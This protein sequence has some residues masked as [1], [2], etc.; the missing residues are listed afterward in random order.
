MRITQVG[1][2]FYS[3]PKSNV[4]ANKFLK[5]APNS[6]GADFFSFKGG[7]ALDKDKVSIIASAKPTELELGIEKDTGIKPV[8]TQVKKFQNGE[9]YVNIAGNVRG[10]DVY[11][12]P[13]NGENVNDNLMETYL[14][15]DAA[16]R[17][18]AHKVIAV[19]PNF[20]YARQEKRTEQG[21]PVAA[22]LNMDL[23]KT[24][25]VDEIITSDLHTPAIEGFAGNDMPITHLESY[26]VMR[27]YIA[28][29]NIPDLVVVSPDAGGMK[30]AEKFAKSLGCD[31]AMIHKCRQAHNEAAAEY[32][33][34]DVKDKN[35]I[36]YDDIIDTAGTISTAAEMLK[37]H[38]AKDIY[39]CASHGLFNG[40]ALQRLNNAPV[41]EV[42]VTNSVPDKTH[43]NSK[44]HQVD[45]SSQI[46]DAM[47]QISA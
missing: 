46:A 33:A 14:K 47:R 6:K 34:G 1:K 8:E 30:R 26:S 17:A 7:A 31:K 20:D 13:A 16:K 38:G 32:L 19:M 18:G 40:R 27:D 21:E 4:S 36:I 22:R 41:K 28:E 37:E 45:I 42:I 24:S 43:G 10:K 11:L 3:Y 9:I 23:L 2:P 35:C 39:I 12:M 25:G 29:K 44:I 5:S 15:A